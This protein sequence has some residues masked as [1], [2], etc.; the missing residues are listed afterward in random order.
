MKKWRNNPNRPLED[1][2]TLERTN[3]CRRLNPHIC[4]NHSVPDICA[5]VRSD[6]VC[7]LPP[8]NWEG[9]YEQLSQKLSPVAE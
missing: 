5:F 6:N 7:M 9:T 3:G 1:G 4:K 2:E 8:N